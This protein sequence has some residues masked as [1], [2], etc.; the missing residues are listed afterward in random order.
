[1]SPQ[2]GAR[3]AL[4]LPALALL[5]LL[6]AC[7][8]QPVRPAAAQAA[9]PPPTPV[10]VVTLQRQELPV[11]TLL[12]G[13]TTAFQVAEIRPQVGGVVRERLFTEGQVVT[14]GQPLFQIDP[15]SYEAAVTR[16]E[17]ALARAEATVRGALA[18]AG[19]YRALVR[20]QAVSQQSLDTAEQTLREAQADV[21]SY[22]AALDSA[23]ID[24]S[25][26][27][28][29]S[30]IAGRS[31]RSSVTP[32]ALVT[33]NQTT[34]LV[35]VTQLDPIYVDVTQPSALLLQQ[36][37]DI[38]SGALRRPS[39]DRAVARLILE[40]GTEYPHAGEIRVAEVIVDQGTGSVTLRAVFPNPDQLLLPGMFVRARV[41]EG[42][43]D[44]ALLV[45]QQGVSRT[46][47]GEP[48]ALVVNAEG[49]VEQRLLQT[50]RAI[51]TDWL[52]TDGLAPG[53]RVVVEGVQRIRAGAR[54]NATERAA[55]PAP[56]ARPAS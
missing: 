21:L 28:V 19:R 42:V 1:M 50:N 40:D 5:A 43:T 24:L 56:A 45:P 20:S 9:A 46:P 30:P 51:G 7:E 41:E 22:R 6:A 18:T 36:R 27:R 55:A 39:A 4:R 23:R 48:M 49:V 8:E 17:A 11:T 33:A 44:R 3:L 14:A 32:G 2:H 25:Y 15:A 37:R 29:T 26:T 47:R 13:R 12:P 54:V 34:A 38:A 10:T 35:T 53:D 16:A 31:G 52:V